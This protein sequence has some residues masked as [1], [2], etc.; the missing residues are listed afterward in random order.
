VLRIVLPSTKSLELLRARDE[1]G[2]RETLR[3]ETLLPEFSERA[4][5][6][7]IE[8]ITGDGDEARVARTGVHVTPEHG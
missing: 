7:G 1:V 5:S 4:Y 2:P 6:E 3:P 8:Q